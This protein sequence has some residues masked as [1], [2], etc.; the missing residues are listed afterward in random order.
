MQN[1]VK[2]N[3]LYFLK[4][5]D[6]NIKYLLIHFY[7][8]IGKK[9]Y[10]VRIKISKKNPEN[11]SLKEFN[12]LEYSIISFTWYEKRFYPLPG[13]VPKEKIIEERSKIKYYPNE[14]G[15]LLEYS[16]QLDIDKNDIKD[17]KYL[18]N[19]NLD[20]PRNE[21]TPWAEHNYY[22]Y[23]YDKKFTNK[24]IERYKLYNLREGACFN[25][26]YSDKMRAMEL[27]LFLEADAWV[28]KYL[29]EHPNLS[30]EEEYNEDS[31]TYVGNDLIEEISSK[32]ID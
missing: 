1:I 7:K 23:I 18:G 29:K 22:Y 20:I 8:K 15:M 17:L 11:M 24:I 4:T 27:K 14:Y 10:L 16:L 28:E 6:S 9:S 25:K 12:N 30:E 3:D 5:N 31:L 26:E 21:Y 13:N 19:Y 32:Y 2:E